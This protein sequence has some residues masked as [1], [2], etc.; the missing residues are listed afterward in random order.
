MTKQ[1]SKRATFE[2]VG[3]AQ[4]KLR[5]YIDNCIKNNSILEIEEREEFIKL[6][7]NST[8]GIGKDFRFVFKTKEGHF[9]LGSVEYAAYWLAYQTNEKIM[10]KEKQF[11]IKDIWYQLRDNLFTVFPH[12]I[13]MSVKISKEQTHLG[14]SEPGLV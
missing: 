9:D 10:F 13:T 3:L 4:D 1:Q 8:L 2:D 5:E 6:L 11:D 7:R 14:A 12:A